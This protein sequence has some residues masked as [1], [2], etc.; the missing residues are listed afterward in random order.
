[1]FGTYGVLN[2]YDGVIKGIDDSIF[3]NITELED[4]TQ[5]KDYTEEID[6]KTYKVT[7][8]EEIT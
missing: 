8:L 3:G 7:E 6:E 5:R 1:M 4:N 2:I